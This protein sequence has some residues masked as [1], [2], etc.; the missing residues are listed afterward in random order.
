MTSKGHYEPIV[1]SPRGHSPAL[2]LGLPQAMAEDTKRFQPG[3]GLK[4]L[5]GRALGKPDHQI[6]CVLM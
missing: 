5:R 1:H 4:A 6:F 3:L 2:T